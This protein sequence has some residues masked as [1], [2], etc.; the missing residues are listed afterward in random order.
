MKHDLDSC[1]VRRAFVASVDEGLEQPLG[2]EGD[3]WVR[4]RGLEGENAEKG[5]RD[6]EIDRWRR[7]EER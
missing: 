6:D 4:Q 7:W 2:F 3:D 1:R 5:R